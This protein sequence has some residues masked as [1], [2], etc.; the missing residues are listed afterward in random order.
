MSILAEMSVE[1]KSTVIGMRS[2]S[3]YNHS[4]QLFDIYIKDVY[5]CRTV[6]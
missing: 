2:K 3:C 6:G 5:S 1:I 4:T